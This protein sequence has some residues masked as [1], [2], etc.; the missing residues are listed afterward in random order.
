MDSFNF[1]E[2]P[3]YADAYSKL[4][5]PGTYYLAFRDLPAI[6]AQY[7]K[8][9]RAID[10]GCGAGR[11]TRFLRKLGF[12]AVGMDVSEEMVQKARRIDPDGD[13]CLISDGDFSGF[14]DGAFD[15]V[16]SAFTFDNVPTM[17]KVRLLSGLGRLLHPGGT[18]VNLV[19]SPEIYTHEWASFSTKNHPENKLARSGDEVRILNTAIADARPVVDIVVTDESYREMYARSELEVVNMFKPLGKEDEPFS[20]VNEKTI[21]PWVIYVLQRKASN[22]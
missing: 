17:D 19:S 10:F 9:K 11:S 15:L 22:I 2:D 6:L 8:G 13:Y 5:F 7:V 1:Y 18:M 12:D 3:L 4:E 16:L 21:A 20:W 14:E